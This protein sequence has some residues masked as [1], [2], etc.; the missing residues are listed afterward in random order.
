[1]W[2]FKN[3]DQKNLGI[4]FVVINSRLGSDFL[5]D[6]AKGGQEKVSGL[7]LYLIYD[8]DNDDNETD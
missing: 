4:I 3:Q 6:M 2:F 7:R 1:M 5:V 8:K